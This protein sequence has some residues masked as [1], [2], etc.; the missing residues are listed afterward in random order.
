[1]VIDT[2]RGVL[3]NTRQRR[4]IL[5][6]LRGTGCHPTAEWIYS[7]VKVEFPRLSLGT[8]YRNLRLLKEGGEITEI[9]FGSTYR[10]FCGRSRNHYHFSCSKCGKVFDVEIPIEANL[11]RKAAQAT[12]FSIEDHSA[13]FYGICKECLEK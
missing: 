8:V 13:V 10:R 4:R 11:D 7:Q 1:M 5:E 2:T 6:V 12:D 9:D 3:K